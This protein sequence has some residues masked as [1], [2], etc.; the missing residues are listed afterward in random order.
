MWGYLVKHLEV[1]GLTDLCFVLVLVWRL[2]CPNFTDTC[3]VGIN[4]PNIPHR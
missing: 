1:R 2:K 4:T 3:S